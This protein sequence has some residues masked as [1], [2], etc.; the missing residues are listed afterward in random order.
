M[1][2]LRYNIALVVANILFGASFSVYVS[3]L[4]TALGF[5]ELFVMQIVC[6][7]VIFVPIAVCNPR[8]WRLSL[9]DFGTIFIVALLVV[10]GWWYMLLWGASYTNPIDASTLS[11]VGP[12]FTLLA[13][14]AVRSQGVERNDVAGVVVALSGAAV[15][16]FDRGS[17]LFG[18]G[19][20][21]YGN[22]LVV[23]AVMSI[24]INTVIIAPVLRRYG[25]VVVMGWYYIIGAVLA[26]PLVVELLPTIDIAHLTPLERGELVY[27]L[28][29][30]TALPMYL[31]YVGSEHLT[32]VHTA[33]YRYLQPVVATTLAVV[34]GQS[35]ID[36]AN[37]VGAALIFLGI[38]FVVL[39]TLAKSSP[40]HARQRR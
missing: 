12:A 19:G 10:F 28:L 1:G 27:I 39:S 33:L 18:E 24:A 2:P 9:E 22:A 6:S 13:A 4:D 15:L 32:A 7:A 11:T 37:V 17:R 31:L 5:G 25:T 23:C 35:N 34:R 40:R 21:G 16:L 3:L 26:L 14:M 30:G 38:L 36:R 29:F 8:F 20:E